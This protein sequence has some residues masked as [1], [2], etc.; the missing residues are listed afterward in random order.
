MNRK[1]S[2]RFEG[3]QNEKK[4]ANLNH[5]SFDDDGLCWNLLGD[6]VDRENGSF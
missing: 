2:F 6:E 3:G 4:M 1:A 5:S